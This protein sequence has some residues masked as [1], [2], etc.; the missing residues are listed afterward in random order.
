MKR[1]GRKLSK[2]SLKDSHQH[3]E[4]SH[5]YTV[6]PVPS[7]QDLVVR[8]MA[9]SHGKHIEHKRDDSGYDSMQSKAKSIRASTDTKKGANWKWLDLWERLAGLRLGPP[10]PLYEE[11]QVELFTLF[12]CALNFLLISTFSVSGINSF[13]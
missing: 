9:E 13:G 7:I 11:F 1:L 3:L 10:P 8:Q 5:K 6:P 2:N 4:D 12:G